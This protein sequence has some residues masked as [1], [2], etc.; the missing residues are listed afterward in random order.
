MKSTTLNQLFAI[1]LAGLLAS[2]SSPSSPVTRV[3]VS[4]SSGKAVSGSALSRQVFDEVNSYRERNGKSILERHAGL[5][6]LAQEHCD[7]IAK[8]CGGSGLNINHENFSKRAFNA[9]RYFHIPS[10]GENVVSSS[11]RTSSHLLSLWVSSKS[12]E[13]NMRGSWAYTGIGTATAPDGMVIS[14]QIFG[15]S[16]ANPNLDSRDFARPW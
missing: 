1:T 13:K 4:A 3:S 9:N 5:D 12:H 7:Y 6:Q 8:T 2:C 15:S 10:V 16:E 14:T 11:T